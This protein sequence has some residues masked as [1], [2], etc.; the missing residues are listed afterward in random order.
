MDKVVYEKVV[1]GK[2]LNRIF[3]DIGKL[4]IFENYLVHVETID[5]TEH[6]FI[7]SMKNGNTEVKDLYVSSSNLS[8]LK[9]V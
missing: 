6:N 2:N 8:T 9:T 3:N 5:G 1:T 4:D 7:N